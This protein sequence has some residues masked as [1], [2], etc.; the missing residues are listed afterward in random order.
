MRSLVLI[1]IVIAAILTSCN[2]EGQNPDKLIERVLSNL[3]KDYGITNAKVIDVYQCVDVLKSDKLIKIRGNEYKFYDEGWG[4]DTI[5]LRGEPPFSDF[6]MITFLIESQDLKEVYT[7][8][9]SQYLYNQIG[10]FDKVGKTKA[11]NNNWISSDSLFFEEDRL[12]FG[13]DRPRMPRESQKGIRYWNMVIGEWNEDKTFEEVSYFDF[14]WL[15][16]SQSIH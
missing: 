2:Q 10:T 11:Q 4:P 8:T 5:Y 14:S 3:E 1:T 6:F 7:Y 9:A 16:K 15:D 12:S 13:D